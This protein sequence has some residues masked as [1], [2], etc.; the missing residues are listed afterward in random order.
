MY[1]AD[2]AAAIVSDRMYGISPMIDTM[3]SIPFCRHFLV[4]MENVSTF[5]GPVVVIVENDMPVPADTDV[6]V[7]TFHV[8]F[9]DRS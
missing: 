3:L 5:T 9:E 6:T 7:P 2:P 4:D 8:L 1:F